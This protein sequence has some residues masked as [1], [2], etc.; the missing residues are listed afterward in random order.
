MDGKVKVFLW[1]G[2]EKKEVQ[3]E[4]RIEGGQPRFWFTE[5]PEHPRREREG[6]SEAKPAPE[7]RNEESTA[8]DVSGMS[9]VEPE[10]TWAEL[11]TSLVEKV[12]S[13]EHENE[14]LKKVVQ[15]M[16]ANAA[17]QTEAIRATAERCSML[18]RG[19]LEIV[20]MSGSTRHSTRVSGHRLMTW[21][22]RF[23]N[24][25]KTSCTW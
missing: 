17:G 21:R 9:E 14:E 18:E 13:L 19:F 7:V 11:V 2:K 12:A 20:N 16:E 1:R 6:E 24:I 4:K 23:G 8:E 10:E 22:A 3:V 5:R 25:K 15:A